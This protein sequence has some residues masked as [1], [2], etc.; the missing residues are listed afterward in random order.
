MKKWGENK[1]KDW[2]EEVGEKTGGSFSYSYDCVGGASRLLLSPS[3][4]NV[5]LVIYFCESVRVVR[6]VI[7]GVGVSG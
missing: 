4:V 5:S 3:P 7:R 6:R 1:K 2:I